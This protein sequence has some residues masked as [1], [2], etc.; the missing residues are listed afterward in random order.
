MFQH[1]ACFTQSVF[2]DILSM[3]D[4]QCIYKYSTLILID[5]VSLTRTIDRV[6][7]LKK[8]F[9][10]FSQIFLFIEDLLVFPLFLSFVVEENQ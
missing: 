1:V 8:N 6:I 7:I 3:Y 2:F 10:C 9:S 4:F 5:L